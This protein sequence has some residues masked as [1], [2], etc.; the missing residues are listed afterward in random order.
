MNDPDVSLLTTLHRLANDW[1]G[2]FNLDQCSTRT[3]GVAA[4]STKLALRTVSFPM[5]KKVLLKSR[6]AQS[7][8]YA[9]ISQDVMEVDILQVKMTRLVP[10]FT[11][12][13]TQQEQ[14]S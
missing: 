5:R 13:Q 10:S 6:E 9:I 2:Y 3:N 11:R 1:R 12:L 14:V 8:T 7:S 4:E